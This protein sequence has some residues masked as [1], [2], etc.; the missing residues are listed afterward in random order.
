MGDGRGRCPPRSGWDGCQAPWLSGAK[1]VSEPNVNRERSPTFI[2]R[3]CLGTLKTCPCVL[4][5]EGEAVGVQLPLQWDA[6]GNS[7]CIFKLK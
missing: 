1:W 5:G 6:A 4:I 2:F 3:G 7:A